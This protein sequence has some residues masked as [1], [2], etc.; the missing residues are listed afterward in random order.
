MSDRWALIPVVRHSLETT[1]MSKLMLLNICS[2][3]PTTNLLSVEGRNAGSS[4]VVRLCGF[5]RTSVCRRRIGACSL[6]PASGDMLWFA[7]PVGRCSLNPPVIFR[8][9]D[10]SESESLFKARRGRLLRLGAC[11]AESIT[12]LPVWVCST[13]PLSIGD[14]RPGFAAVTKPSLPL[15]ING[16]MSKLPYVEKE[17]SAN[18]RSTSTDYFPHEYGR[19]SHKIN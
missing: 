6:S 19:G 17:Q 18:N 1:L 16:K 13:C 12:S 7:E 4:R 3:I 11:S 9:F 15:S 10:A 14:S 2:Q 5:S 8:R